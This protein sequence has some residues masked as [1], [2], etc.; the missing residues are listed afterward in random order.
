MR[1]L[2]IVAA[3]V[4]ALLWAPSAWAQQRGS[5]TTDQPAMSFVRDGGP[6]TRP[7]DLSVFAGTPGALLVGFGGGVRVSFPL[8]HDGF[9]GSINNAVRF[10]TGAEFYHW[11]FGG[12]AYETIAVPLQ[13][14]W[15]FFLTEQWTVFAAAGVALNVY[16]FEDDAGFFDAPK[17]T[18]L[19]GFGSGALITSAVGFGALI[20]F[21][22]SVSL[23]LDAT[24]NLLAIGLTFRM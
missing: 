14:R 16:Y 6:H 4:A 13:L 7:I 22:E 24:L 20:N 9:I 23:R 19:W 17:N 15:D 1:R 2:P 8:M 18:D 12:F 5:L 11:S 10:E 21:S 3:V